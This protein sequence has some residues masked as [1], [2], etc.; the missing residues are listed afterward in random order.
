MRLSQ[1]AR[2]LNVTQSE[3][4]KLF[5]NAGI[6]SPKGGNTKLSEEQLALITKKFGELVE[7]PEVEET[8]EVVEVVEVVETIEADLIPEPVEAEN[9]PEPVEEVIAEK[10]I[11][12]TEVVGEAEIVEEAAK[13]A[14]IEV[15][16]VK[17]VKL[18]GI[19]VLGKIDLPEPIVKKAEKKEEESIEEPVKPE[20]TSSN[21]NQQFTN[22]NR[23]KPHKKAPLTFEQ[24]QAL[25]EKK[26]EKA[27][28]D[29]ERKLKEKK[30]SHYQTNVQKKSVAATPKKKKVVKDISKSKSGRTKITT[31]NPFKRFWIWLNDP[32]A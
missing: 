17:K 7:E 23:R 4:V 14:E 22:K 15:I 29:R 31:R 3:I 13:A 6:E 1:I 19:K 9:I 16:R 26:R 21:R 11:I 5:V 10:E 25:E 8:A 2:K 30:R 12:E 32:Y 20:R 24:K 18:D 28:K 27:K